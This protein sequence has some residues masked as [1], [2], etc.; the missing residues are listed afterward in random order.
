MQTSLPRLH[1]NIPA[2][3]FDL[4][5]L[6]SYEPP[7]RWRPEPG[8]RVQGQ[9]VKIEDRR[10]FGRSAPTL[11]VL[12]PPTTGDEHDDRYMV[13]RASGVVLRSAIDQLRPLP[14]EE[15]AVRYEGMRTTADG[16][17]TYA[18]HRM[19]VRRNGRWMVAQ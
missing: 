5:E 18:Y 10:S 6:L 12:V 4:A 9:L 1:P 14:D 17:R 16:T 13:I 8:D 15:V 11:F 3:R 2:G 19:A 7:T